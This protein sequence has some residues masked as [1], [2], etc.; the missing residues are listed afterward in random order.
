MRSQV[1]FSLLCAETVRD[2]ADDDDDDAGHAASRKFRGFPF[3]PIALRS[4]RA[5]RLRNLTRA[6]NLKVF[7]FFFTLQDNMQW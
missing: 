4:D 3:T 2:A 5:Q 1:S 6:Y 7:S